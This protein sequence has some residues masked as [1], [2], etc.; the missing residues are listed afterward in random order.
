[1]HNQAKKS[2]LL[3]FP[4]RQLPNMISSKSILWTARANGIK[5]S[6]SKDLQITVSLSEF[7]LWAGMQNG[8]KPSLA[9]TSA[10]TF[11]LALHATLGQKDMKRLRMCA[12][13]I[14]IVLRQ[15]LLQLP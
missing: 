8:M 11:D 7:I 12:W 6:L 13:L 9:L 3:L 10:L 15:R 4:S 14:Q 2:C 5:R 1:M